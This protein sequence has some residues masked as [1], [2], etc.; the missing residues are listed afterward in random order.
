MGDSASGILQRSGVNKAVGTTV[1]LGGKALTLSKDAVVAVDKKVNDLGKLLQQ[2]EPVKNLDATVS[3]LQADI[4]SKLEQGPV[5]KDIMSMVDKYAQFAKDNPVKSALIVGALTS[6]A[7]IAGGP[8]AARLLIKNQMVYYKVK[9]FQQHLA[10]DKDSFGA[11][12]GYAFNAL[13]DWFDGIA[14]E[15]APLINKVLLLLK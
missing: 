6:V 12:A 1:K 11:I 7:A 10:S 5:G 2:T 3:K 14:Y 8:G 15:Q 13:S 9:S 4:R